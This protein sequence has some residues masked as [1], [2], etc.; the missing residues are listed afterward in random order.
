VRIDVKCKSPVD[1]HDHRTGGRD[2]TGFRWDKAHLFAYYSMTGQ[3][4][5]DIFALYE[6]L[7]THGDCN[8]D[9]HSLT[10]SVN[11]LLMGCIVHQLTLYHSIRAVF[12]HFD[13]TRS[14]HCLRRILLMHMVFGL[15]WENLARDRYFVISNRQNMNTNLPLEQKTQQAENNL[16]MS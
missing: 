13:G 16:R 11:L 15:L 10:L 9:V 14:Y 4:L 6:L 12:T 2:V 5:N 7:S 8:D 1:K 3:L